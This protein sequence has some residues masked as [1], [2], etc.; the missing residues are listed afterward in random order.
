MNQI[1]AKSELVPT[2]KKFIVETP[3]IAGKIKAGQFIVLRYREEGE[4]IPL[5]IADF[6]SEA[7]T[8]TLI[9]KEIGKSTMELGNLN[10]GDTILDLIGPLGTPSHVEKF[11]TVVAVGGG[12]G[13]APV[14]PL[15]KAL[16][17]VGNKII[18]IIGAQSESQL[19]LVEEAKKYSDEVIITTDDGSAGRKGLVTEALQGLIDGGEK[20]DY[21]FAAGPAI[22]MKFVAK[23]T[24]PYKIKTDVSL[25]S[26]MVDGT[27]MCGACRVSVGD[28]TKF[29]CVDGPDFDGHEVD[30]DLLMTRQ[31][32]Y[33]VEESRAKKLCDCGCAS[34]ER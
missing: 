25:N 12:I 5:S 32:M 1:L 22:M 13:T 24:E 9:F 3:D 31:R 7:G 30:F 28:K 16:K 34:E 21:V 17:E 19:I 8:I 27:G 33:E 26:I 18:T 15:I 23:T 29:A 14:L 4:R 2:V 10:E 6:D 20:I 11:G